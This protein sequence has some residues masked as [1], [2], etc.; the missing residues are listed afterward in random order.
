[1]S[2]VR[3]PNL[4]LLVAG[5]LAALVL[6]VASTV[7]LAAASGA[8]GSAPSGTGCAVPRLPGA[9]VE[10]T[11]AD[12]GAMMGGPMPGGMGMA[13][14]VANPGV[15]A[16]GTLSL[17]VVNQGPRTHELVVLPVPAGQAVGRR[18]VGTDGRV[19]E[20]GSLGE[21]SHTCGAGAGDGIDAGAVGWLTLTLEPGRY[22]LV[23]NLPG[24]YAAGMYT[25]LVVS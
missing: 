9:V 21:A 24:H 11:L 20:A 3:R 7:G 25:E 15:V 6:G 8:F 22:E 13:R 17:R 18:P 10:V 19:D 12:M 1:V 16:A 23:C 5:T 14:V 4:Q 2:A